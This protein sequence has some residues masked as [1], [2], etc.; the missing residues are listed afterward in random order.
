MQTRDHKMLALRLLQDADNSE[1]NRHGK[2]FVLGCIEPDY[3]VL[4][5][6][7]GSLSHAVL[8]G[9]NAENIR[10]HI[11]RKLE[12]LQRRGLHSAQSC[13]TLGTILHYVA[14]TFTF[15]HNMEFGGSMAEHI[16]YEGTLHEVFA[17]KLSICKKDMTPI[18]NYS[19]WSLFQYEYMNYCDTHHTIE[20][21]CEY[22]LRVCTIILGRIMNTVP[23]GVHRT[24]IFYG[25]DTYL[26]GKGVTV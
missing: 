14:D 16:Y 8:R 5:Y 26:F 10:R 4:T 18:G 12:A 2:A 3:N 23:I 24:N 20:G 9:H 7:R 19:A 6:I 1:L 21:D 22:I 25:K 15:P 13:F 11:H 17:K